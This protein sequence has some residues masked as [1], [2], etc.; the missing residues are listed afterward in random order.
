MPYAPVYQSW[1]RLRDY[2]EKFKWIDPT[3]HLPTIGY[4][5]PKGIKQWERVP[6]HITYV[7]GDGKLEKGYCTCIKVDR[8]THKRML[9][10]VESKQIRWVRDYFVI[11]VDGTRFIN[12]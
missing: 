1:Q 3:T 9:Q 7:T 5:V 2:C 11:E 10:F 6:F 4:S 8:R 12:H